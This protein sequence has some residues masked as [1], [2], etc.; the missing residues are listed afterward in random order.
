MNLTSAARTKTE[1]GWQEEVGL[2]RLGIPTIKAKIDSGARTSALHA[3]DLEPFERDGKDWIAFRVPLTGEC[4]ARVCRAPIAD[5]RPIKNTSGIPEDRYVI[6]TRLVLGNRHWRI[7]LSLADRENMGFDLILGRTA[8]R[9]RGLLI[10]PGRSFLTGCP[11][12]LPDNADGK[13]P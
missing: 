2:P 10:N 12:I 1:I 6:R 13:H 11:V 4:E 5:E 8:I 3:V 7:E 9:R